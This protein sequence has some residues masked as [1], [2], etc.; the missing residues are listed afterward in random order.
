MDGDGDDDGAGGVVVDTLAGAAA[1][2]SRD[3]AVDDEPTGEEEGVVDV[4]ELDGVTIASAG[5]DEGDVRT[6]GDDVDVS[7]PGSDGAEGGRC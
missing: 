1:G 4:V 5:V 3:V 6:A 2:A 7:A